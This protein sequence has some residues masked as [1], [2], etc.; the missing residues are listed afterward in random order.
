M[1]ACRD[2]GIWL[3]WLNVRMTEEQFGLHVASQQSR[4]TIKELLYMFDLIMPE[5]DT[6]ST[7]VGTIVKGGYST[8]C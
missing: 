1:H 3:A 4:G 2:R 8:C 5:A 6:V 7:A